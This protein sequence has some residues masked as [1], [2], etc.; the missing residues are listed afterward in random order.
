MGGSGHMLIWEGAAICMAIIALGVL[1]T[2]VSKNANASGVMNSFSSFL[3]SG[4]ATAQGPVS[5]YSPGAPIYASG[6][7]TQTLNTGNGSLV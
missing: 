3:N 4:I 1:A 5:G 7:T 6:G 2:I